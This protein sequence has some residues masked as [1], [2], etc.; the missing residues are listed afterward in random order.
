MNDAAVEE[1]VVPPLGFPAGMVSVAVWLVGERAPVV[2]GDRVVQLVA[3]AATVD[4]VA[5]VTGRLERQC[6]DEDE[7]VE[8]GTR[9][10]MFT[11]SKGPHP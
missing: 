5:P 11:A 3:G 1:L 4:L 7:A 8:P 2:A 10:A 9:L 6:V